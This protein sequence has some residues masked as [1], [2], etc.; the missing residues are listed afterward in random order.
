[1]RAAI[2][3]RARLGWIA[4]TFLLAASVLHAQQNSGTPGVPSGPVS[5]KQA[6]DFAAKNQPA[7]RASLA[8]VQAAASGIDLAKT[9][10]L[11]KT[12]LLLQFNRAT[13]NNV[14]GLILPNGV[15]PAIS[16]PVQDA[17]PA[18]TTF[19]SA[20]GA[21]F[22]WEPF[23]F[24][25]RKADVDVAEALRRKAQ[26]GAAVTEYEISLAVT[27]AFLAAVA[28]QQAVEAAKATVER[29]QVFHDAVAVLVKNELRPGAD[30][31][32]ARAELAQAT[33][34]LIRAE[35]Q[36][37]AARA[38]LAEWMGVAGENVEIA[39]GPLLNEPP[40]EGAVVAELSS[41]P[42]SREQQAEVDVTLAKLRS[43]DK[44]WRPKF[45]VLSALYARGT[46]AAVD[47][48]FLG[49]A[50]G[51]APSEGNW[52][53]GVN[54]RFPIFDFKQN[55]VRREI[56][57][58][59][60]E[61]GMARQE[62]VVQELKGRVER[63]R[64]AVEA[65]RRIAGN[66]PVEMEAALQLETQAQARYKAGLGTVME[67]AEAHRLLRR[68]EVDDSLARLGIWQAL[69]AEAAAR[70]AMDELLERGSR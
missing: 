26:A 2:S 70:G 12:D 8:E 49:G 54:V 27:E 46:G 21:L 65:A 18:T 10:Y 45:E 68:A 13:R 38:T 41:H 51:L 43:L 39:A 61:A 9:A 32:R 29:M 59:H 4:A 40:S 15:I 23:D 44:E 48:T 35:Q 24:G 28:N 67:V 63:A 3:Q 7:V 33:N 1:M 37:A 19:G 36:A 31:S 34:D 17:A 25:L 6:V 47:G 50:N 56:E 14:F 30:E 55:R 57:T 58:H 66:T 69:F 16:G 53:V 52:A 64:I 11:P 60:E 20:A 42:L 22:S 62:S 5:L